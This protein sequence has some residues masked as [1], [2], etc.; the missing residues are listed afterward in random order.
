[1]GVHQGCFQGCFALRQC[2]RERDRRGKKHHHDKH[3]REDLCPTH[4]GKLP[5][6]YP[7]RVGIVLQDSTSET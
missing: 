1:M 7:F 4:M 2:W 3:P 5:G 6:S